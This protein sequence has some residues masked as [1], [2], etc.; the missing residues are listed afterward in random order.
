MKLNVEAAIIRSSVAGMKILQHMNDVGIELSRRSK[1]SSA[2]LSVGLDKDASILKPV[3]REVISSQNKDGGYESTKE[4]TQCLRFL[5]YFK[6]KNTY[7]PTIEKALKWL[8][9]LQNKNGGYGDSERD[10]SRIPVTS[11]VLEIFYLYQSF[12]IPQKI[13]KKACNWLE[14][15]W[16][17]D[18]SNYG[19]SYKCSGFLK[20]AA[21]FPYFFNEE[22]ITK[23][24]L[25]LYNDQNK[26]GGWG[27]NKYSYVG[28]VPS[29]TAFAIEAL[30]YHYPKRSD[31]NKINK[32]IKWLIKNQLNI[33]LWKEHHP[34]HALA[35]ILKTLEFYNKLK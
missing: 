19:L 9:S 11:L 17:H 18:M 21:Y 28:S 4:T 3:L 10:R 1:L 31:I 5:Y 7:I 20:S 30:L 12:G 16:L 35:P 33:G 2:L 13:I 15:E 29:Y 14:K 32:G 27:P 24:I 8:I 23:S 26:D 22:V 34:D 6:D 25:W